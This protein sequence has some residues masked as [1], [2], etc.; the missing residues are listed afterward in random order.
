MP[1]LNLKANTPTQQLVKDYLEKSASAT[2]ADKINHGVKIQKDGKTVLNKKDLNGFMNFACDEARKQT[3]K[4]AKSACI[5]DS[6]VYGWAIHY[7]EEASV[8]GTLYNEDGTLYK[9]TPTD[10][11]RNP[12]STVL[13]IPPVKKP[14]PQMSLFELMEQ[15]NEISETDTE[16]EPDETDDEDEDEPLPETEETLSEAPPEAPAPL[17]EKEIPAPTPAVQPQSSP[18]Y[19]RYMKIQAQYPDAVIV[20]R[21]GDFY[22]ILGES[23]VKIAEELALT[24]TGRDCGLESRV[25]MVGFPVH[26]SDVYISKLIANGYKLAI[27]EKSDEIRIQQPNVKIDEETGEL[28]PPVSADAPASE[29]EPDDE[30]QTEMDAMKAFEPVTLAKLYEILGDELDLQ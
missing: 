14:K 15:Q 19:Q 3:E 10:V 16:D 28:L 30:L 17:P 25:P 11:T 12:A 24:L 20:W 13:P 2:L 22:E 23:A 6:T 18:L 9:S 7:F 26:S 29:D 8:E 21:H 27:V 1:I 4:S 5:E